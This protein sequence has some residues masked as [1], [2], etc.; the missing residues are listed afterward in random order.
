[1]S[2]DRAGI[3]EDD[4]LVAQPLARGG[5][6]LGVFRHAAQPVRPP[7][8]LGR[9]VALLADAA[10]LG[11]RLRRGIPEQDG[12]IGQTRLGTLIPQELVDRRLEATSE[13]I[14]YGDVD[15]GE[16]VLGLQEI[17]A[18]GADE[19]ADAIDIGNVVEGLPEYRV[20]HGFAGAVRHGADE[21]GDGD[22]WRGFALAPADVWPR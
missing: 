5:D 4:P 2:P 11:Q 19:I 21:T 16:G 14:P 22:Q 6:L 18:I 1:M 20:A 15:P 13:E 8:E 9:D 17:E 12:R 3:N 7:A 10:R